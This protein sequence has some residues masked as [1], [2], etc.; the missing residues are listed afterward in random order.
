[1]SRRSKAQRKR[2]QQLRQK[3]GWEPRAPKSAALRDR[4]APKR[5]TAKEARATVLSYR[6]RIYG[7][8]E[9]QARDQDAATFIGRAYLMSQLSLDQKHTAKWF[10]EAVF[11]YRNAVQA[12]SR[13]RGKSGFAEFDSEDYERYCERA[14]ETFN[15]IVAV[16][17]ERDIAT[18]TTNSLGLL[19]AAIVRDVEN[20]PQIGEIREVLNVLET[21]KS[22][23]DYEGG[24]IA[25]ENLKKESL[26]SEEKCA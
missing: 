17:R 14:I 23:G 20:W 7:L 9:S 12:P 11:Q 21:W 22:K 8:T 6:Q 2:D 15:G 18:R 16:L 26:V 13:S 24:C 5:E 25:W 19:E 1:M 4:F 10:L 3:L